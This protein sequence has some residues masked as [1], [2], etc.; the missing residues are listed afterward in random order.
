LLNKKF[1]KSNNDFVMKYILKDTKLCTFWS[2]N[3]KMGQDQRTLNLLSHRGVI[4]LDI[5]INQLKE[6]SIKCF[7]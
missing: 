7:S 2:E 5:A 1:N 6:Q 4:E 3:L